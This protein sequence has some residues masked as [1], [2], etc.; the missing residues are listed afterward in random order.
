MRPPAGAGADRVTGWRSLLLL[1]VAGA[2]IV[3]VI[4]QGPIAQ[5]ADYHQ[6][7]DQRALG[8]ID[9][10]MNV[11]SNA[12][13]VLVGGI[14]LLALWRVPDPPGALPLLRPAYRLFFLGALLIGFGSAWYHLAPDNGSLLWDRL[15]MTLSFMALV[16]IVVGEQIEERIGRR[17]LLPLVAIGLGSVLYWAAGEAR[18]V[19]DLRPYVL[20]QFL[21]M[22]L[23]P[24]ILLLWRSAFESSG[25]LWALIGLYVLAK[26]FEVGD[27]AIF[28]AGGVISGHSL[29]HLAAAVAMAMLLQ[30][31][32]TR[33]RRPI[34]RAAP[35]RI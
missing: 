25:A 8:A 2:A 16:A 23:L 19:G 26:L 30:A 12:G 11:L 34:S 10:Y 9:N 5:P 4:W 18:G 28:A 20:V 14:G 33:R 32:L 15:P 27:A 7:A 22:L 13:F 3:A 31:L 1:A 6:F 21:P 29:K 24:L 17:L 35:P